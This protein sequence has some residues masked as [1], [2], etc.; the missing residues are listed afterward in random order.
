MSGYSSSDDRN[1]VLEEGAKAFVE[2]PCLISD[3]S[4]ALARALG[5]QM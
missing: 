2:K 3:F 4:K 1:I 5:K